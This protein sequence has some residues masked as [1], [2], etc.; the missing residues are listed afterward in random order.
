MHRGELIF[1]NQNQYGQWLLQGAVI[2]I[3]NRYVVPWRGRQ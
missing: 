2:Q 3:G 1:L